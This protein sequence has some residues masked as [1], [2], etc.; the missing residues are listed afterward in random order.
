MNTTTNLPRDSHDYEVITRAIQKIP[1]DSRGLTCE[2]GLRRG[3]G[4]QVIL[5][6]VAAYE[7]CVDTVEMD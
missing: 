3:G 6:A 2:I 4:T 5:D 7:A 1:A